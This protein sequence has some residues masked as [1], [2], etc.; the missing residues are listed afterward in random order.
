MVTYP[1]LV[2]PKR[3][4]SYMM[5]F[6]LYM[7]V[8]SVQFEQVVSPRFFL[9]QA[10]YSICMFFAG[11]ISI[12]SFSYDMKYL[13]DFRPIRK[14]VLYA[15]DSSDFQSS[16]CLVYTFGSVSFK[17]LLPQGKKFS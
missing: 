16:V 17:I 14:V 1:T 12:F 3:H 4:I 6:V 11:L 10:S 2:F 13:S 5:E 9:T 8:I 7:P 15:L